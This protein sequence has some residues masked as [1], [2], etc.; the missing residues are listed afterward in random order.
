MNKLLSML[1]RMPSFLNLLLRFQVNEFVPIS[2]KLHLLLLGGLL[3]LMKAS[4]IQL[5][6][7]PAFQTV[8]LYPSPKIIL[9]DT[10]NQNI[11]LYLLP[12]FKQ[13]AWPFACGMKGIGNTRSER[14]GLTVCAPLAQESPI[15]IQI[16]IAKELLLPLPRTPIILYKLPSIINKNQI[17]TNSQNVQQV[18]KKMRLNNFLDDLCGV[19]IIEKGV[20]K[21]IIELE[22]MEILSSSSC[23]LRGTGGPRTIDFFSSLSSFSHSLLTSEEPLQTELTH[24]P[25]CYYVPAPLPKSVADHN[26]TWPVPE[27]HRSR[28]YGGPGSEARSPLWWFRKSWWGRGCEAC[29]P[30]FRSIGRS[31]LHCQSMIDL[32]FG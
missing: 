11:S 28:S 31:S 13:N 18:L 8:L 30:S 9:L 14:P 21:N 2:C 29:H 24:Q 10:V 26:G 16:Y 20:N 19:F 4:N 22:K 5:P 25:L 15:I 27:E 23:S 6:L 12:S 7:T 32:G 3:V 17:H 1:I